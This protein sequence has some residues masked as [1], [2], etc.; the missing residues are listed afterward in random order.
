MNSIKTLMVAILTFSL[1][2]TVAAQD[3]SEN[4]APTP[5]H[6]GAWFIGGGYIGLDSEVTD[7]QGVG[8]G[9]FTLDMGY[10]GTLSSGFGY[11]VGVYLP[12]IADD[13]EFSQRVEDQFGNEST[14]DSSISAWGILAELGYVHRLNEKTS[15]S[16]MGGFRTLSADR[17]IAN[18]SNCLEEGLNL[19]GGGYL[20]PG[21]IFHNASFD[22]ELAAMTFLSGDMTNGFIVNFRF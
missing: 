12:F 3:G 4:A 11:S 8:G 2:S 19:A 10:S 5:S 6:D 21:I 1:M 17:T 13:G 7:P 9:G 22:V 20:R 16:L 15:L 14:A 18:C